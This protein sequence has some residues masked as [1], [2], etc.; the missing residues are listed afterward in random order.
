MSGTEVD[1]STRNG[2]AWVRLK[3]EFDL[4]A[5]ADV[6]KRLSEVER[7]N[8]AT[9][10]LDLRDLSFIDSTGLRTVL[11][12]DARARRDGRRLVV[13]PGPQAVHRVFRIALLDNRLDFVEEPALLGEGDDAGH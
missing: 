12:A 3:G 11:A 1:V 10:V 13:I 2:D 4:G 7:D 5:A 9:V 6:E 8:P